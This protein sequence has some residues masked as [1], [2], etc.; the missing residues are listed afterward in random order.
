MAS[1]RRSEEEA[2]EHIR[3]S[4]IQRAQFQL[5]I[6]GLGELATNRFGAELLNKA[7]KADEHD[8]Q[9]TVVKKGGVASMSELRQA[10]KTAAYVS[11]E[12]WYGVKTTALRTALVNAAPFLKGL[13]KKTAS[14]AI[15]IVPDGYDT[16]DGTPLIRIYTD[17]AT[18][19]EWITPVRNPSTKGANLRGRPRWKR[20]SMKPTISIVTS[21]VNLEQFG[22]LLNLAGLGGIGE[23][24]PASKDSCGIGMGMFEVVPTDVSA[25]TSKKRKVA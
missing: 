17:Q 25:T 20:W 19:E 9:P 16:T 22:Q 18:P 1:K 7:K 13:T 5:E 8:S 3:I 10:C 23:G 24:R 6:I 12:G 14:Y 2:T 4:P 21:L 15:W 11:T